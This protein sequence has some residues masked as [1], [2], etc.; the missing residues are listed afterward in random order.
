MQSTLHQISHLFLQLDLATWKLCKLSLEAGADKD[1]ANGYGLFSHSKPCSRLCQ[2][3]TVRLVA[4][5]PA[6]RQVRVW[7]FGLHAAGRQ[8]KPLGLPRTGRKKVEDFGEDAPWMGWRS[9]F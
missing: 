9:Y 2:P 6:P 1:T 3:S 8:K 5:R 7:A 4:H